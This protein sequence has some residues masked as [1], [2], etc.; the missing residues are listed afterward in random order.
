[1]Q[2]SIR[3]RAPAASLSSPPA[4]PAR[5]DEPAASIAGVV[6]S[7]PGPDPR[8]PELASA[9]AAPKSH[10]SASQAA[11]L[12]PARVRLPTSESAPWKQILREA[13][14]DPDVLLDRLGLPDELRVGARRAA[15][16][17]PLIVPEGFIRRMR[18]GDPRDPLLRQVLPIADEDRSPPRFVADP[19]AEG[20]A[21][22]AP[23]LL[24]KYHGRALLVAAAVCAVS[25]RY[26]FRRHYPY[27]ESPTGPQAWQPAVDRVAADP[28]IEEII[29]SG[30]DPLMRSDSWLGPFVRQLESISHLRRLRIHTRLPILIPERVDDALIGW[31]SATRLSPWVVVHANHPAEID[32]SVGRALERLVRAG[33]PVLNQSVLLAGVN[34]DV[35]VLAELSTRL[36]DHRVI[37]YYLHQL[38]PVEGAAHFEVPESRGREIVAELRKR[39]PGYGVPSYVKELA[40]EPHKIPIGDAD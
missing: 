38:D 16:G 34:D 18:F 4:D 8:G 6:A 14:R 5:H 31:L 36:L 37:P 10:A 9:P 35:E 20:A 24:H 15:Q 30:G 39:L 1:M 28:T 40:G 26:C 33:I 21:T 27:E 3:S 7:G 25:C 22:R 19:L 23:G 13:V 17:F 32:E 2:E 11:A 12:D 29:L